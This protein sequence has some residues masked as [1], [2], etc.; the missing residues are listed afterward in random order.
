MTFKF[1]YFVEFWMDYYSAKFHCCRLSL[2]GFIDKF[3]K[4]DDVIMT[5]FMFLE[6]ENLKF[7]ETGYRLSSHQ[8]SNLLVAWIKFYGG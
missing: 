6:F 4:K 7:Y 1:L 2:A 3:K 5:S 8:V